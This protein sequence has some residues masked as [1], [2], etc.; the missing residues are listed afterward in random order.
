[1]RPLEPLLPGETRSEYLARV[2][3]QVD[4]TSH[5]YRLGV[6]EVEI[7]TLRRKLDLARHSLFA[8][9]DSRNNRNWRKPEIVQEAERGLSY[10]IPPSPAANVET[11]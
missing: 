10:S 3:G 7:Q 4:R 6:A 1:M 9:V 5:A 11:A 8:I 2:D